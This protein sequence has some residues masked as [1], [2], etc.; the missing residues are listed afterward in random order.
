MHRSTEFPGQRRPSCRDRQEVCGHL[1]KLS[2]GDHP[3]GHV[4]GYLQV[5]S[6]GEHEPQLLQELWADLIPILTLK[7]A[8]C[9]VLD[10]VA[11]LS[12]L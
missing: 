2:A 6:Q 1:R 8:S 3:S 12:D 5:F 7:L 11:N 4:G 9:L 10:K